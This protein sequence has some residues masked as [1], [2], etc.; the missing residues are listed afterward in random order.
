M[1]EKRT[2]QVR[3]P[4]IM[5]ALLWE[6]I[7]LGWEQ[8]HGGVKSH[9]FLAMDDMPAISNWWGL[10]LLP[11]LTWYLA[12]R[13][14]KRIDF[15]GDGKDARSGLP[16]RVI[17]GF[18]VSLV[19]GMLLSFFFTN[20]YDDMTSYLF[21]GMFALAFILPVYRA[22]CLLGFVMGMNFTFG[23]V[24]PTL[25]ASMIASISALVHLLIVP[26]FVNLWTRLTK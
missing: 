18:G 13:I 2:P 7:H 10:L 8:F 5:F 12:G 20:G 19:F 16:V 23:A 26:G 22:E 4:L 9:H 1:A 15:A 11:A 3:L 6:V 21:F 14:Q 17:I 24:L 25:V